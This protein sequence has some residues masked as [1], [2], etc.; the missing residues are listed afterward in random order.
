[1]QTNPDSGLWGY[2]LVGTAAFLLG[3]CAAVVIDLLRRRKKGE[4][5]RHD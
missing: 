2:I 3:G 4:N 1:M 5:R